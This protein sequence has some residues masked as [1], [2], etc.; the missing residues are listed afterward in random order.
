[1]SSHDTGLRVVHSETPVKEIW[2]RLSYF[3]SKHNAREFI[4]KFS[5]PNNN[6]TDVAS[7]LA[8]T[9]KTA[10]EY[11]E[12]AQR[13]SLLTQPLLIF[14]GMTALSK[15]LFISTYG[16][17]SPSKSHGL[18]PPRPE[19]FAKIST[20]IRRDGTF[21]QFH[22]CYSKEKLYRMKF[23]MKELLSS[24]PEVKIEYETIYNEK[25]R[26]LKVL[27]TRYGINVVDTE[28]EKYGDLSTNL[29]KVFPEI[30][31]IQVFEKRLV[32]FSRLSNRQIRAVSGEKY[33]LLP[34]KK[35][36]RN[37]FLPEMSAHFLIMYL[38]GMISR[39]HPKEW[40]ETIKGEESG[41]VYIIQK[42]LKI[43][44][45]KFPNLILN[46]LWDRDFVFT[47]PKV[48]TEAEKRLDGEQLEKIYDYVNRRL[49][50]EIRGY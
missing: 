17:K 37:V 41:E 36:N 4:K 13:V 16:K 23:T 20:R 25:S 50:N 27:R 29:K 12:S 11:Y 44:T 30:N 48:E 35:H 18:S 14:Y 7:S 45:R 40:G 33:L 3:E 26:A 19:L 39:Y 8:F 24:A 5:L 21:P 43:T 34:L 31:T 6:L 46:E 32:I 9:M 38:L 15:V 22:S 49:A 2:S 28:I 10:R 42:F 1:M 47:S